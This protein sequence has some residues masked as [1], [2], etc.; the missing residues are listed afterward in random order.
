MWSTLRE[1][2]LIIRWVTKLKCIGKRIRAARKG[3]GLTQ[4]EVARKSGISQGT[5]ACVEGGGDTTLLVLL[6][7]RRALAPKM[8]PQDWMIKLFS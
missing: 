4:K 5:V 1:I 8:S 3:A 7:L 6:K 2:R